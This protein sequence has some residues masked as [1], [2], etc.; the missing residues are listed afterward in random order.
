MHWRYCS[1]ATSHQYFFYRYSYLYSHQMKLVAV[2]K[3]MAVLK[4]TKPLSELMMIRLM[5]FLSICCWKN[6]ILQTTEQQIIGQKLYSK[7][8]LVEIYD[9]QFISAEA[10]Y[11]GHVT[12]HSRVFY[13][14]TIKGFHYPWSSML[15]SHWNELDV[16][17]PMYSRVP[18]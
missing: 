13:I 14:K 4:C 16:C 6:L 5:K 1:L 17:G 7:S 8:T 2:M 9:N 12:C 3:V 10:V 18:L 11:L 15:L